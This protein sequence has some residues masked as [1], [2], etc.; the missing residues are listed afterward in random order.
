MTRLARRPPPLPTLER[1]ALVALAR[2]GAM[3]LVGGEWRGMGSR[4]RI[5]PLT[6]REL[7][8]LGLAAPDGPERRVIT[9]RGRRTVA[10]G[11]V[12]QGTVARGPA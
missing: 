8:R 3:A 6:M 4:H 1:G 10:Q 7:V 9:A 2:A 5:E 12:A 11:T